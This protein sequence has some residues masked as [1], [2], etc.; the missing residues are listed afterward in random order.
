MQRKHLISRMMMKPMM[1]LHCNSRDD[2]H[3]DTVICSI[4]V[5][6]DDGDDVVVAAT[7]AINDD[8]DDDD[9]DNIII[10]IIIFSVA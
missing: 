2:R 8:D 6:D 10:I 1:S 7:A 3:V 4:A 5:D 9:D